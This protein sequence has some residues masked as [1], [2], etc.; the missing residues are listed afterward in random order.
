MNTET[1]LYAVSAFLVIGGV[2]TLYFY[3]RFLKSRMIPYEYIDLPDECYRRPTPTAEEILNKYPYVE[4]GLDRMYGYQTVI[5]AI[6]EALS[7]EQ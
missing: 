5:N 4:S 7:Y 3:M 1:I 2:V 6:N